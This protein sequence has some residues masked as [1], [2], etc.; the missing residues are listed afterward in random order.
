MMNKIKLLKAS[1][2]YHQY[3]IDFYSAH[4]ELDNLSYSQQMNLLMGDC[5][6]WANF[7]KINLEKTGMFE[8]FE[9]VTNA[10]KI[11][12]QWAKECNVK[13]SKANW[14][15]DILEAQVRVFGPEVFFAH[16]Y[17][18]L[19]FSF[20]DR[21]RK[22][23]GVKTIIG[24]DGIAQNNPE[25]YQGCDIVLSC[26]EDTVKFY[27]QKGFKSYFF[28][29]GFETSVL[30]KLVKRDPLRDVVFSGS[31]FA[32]NNLHNERI[33]F[34]FKIASKINLDL[35]VS[36]ISRRDFLNPFYLKDQLGVSMVDYFGALKIVL[37]NHGP[38]FGLRMYQL[39]SDAKITLNHHIDS[40][41]TKAG[42]MRLFEATGVGS[43]L[44]T[45]WKPNISNF[46]EPDKE[47]VVYK[48]LEECLEKV[49]Y[50]LNNE[51]KRKEIAAAGSRKTA[52]IYSFK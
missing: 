49:N 8:V 9:V 21:I 51:A 42:N 1:P 31:L 30:D 25:A 50:L 27:K 18:N 7:W 11:Q 39:L 28:P 52:E 41:G 22:K 17:S 36:G 4:R 13:Y 43:C 23:Y 3:L 44:V 32:G 24:W 48:N 6:G 15:Q 19:N 35:W 33:K 20:R 40:S 10:E 47:I 37:S 34:L 29:F 16:D 2:F 5:F 12:K 14:L 45:D 26:N 46:F 38:V